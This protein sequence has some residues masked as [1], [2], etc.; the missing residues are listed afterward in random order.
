M[1]VEVAIV[2][3][4]VAGYACAARL[5]RHG[6]PPLLI[7]P[8]LPVDR[9]PLTKTALAKGEP[10]A[11]RRRTAPRAGHR[12]ARRRRRPGRPRAAPGAVV[13]GRSRSRR[14]RSCSRRAS[15]SAPPIP[16]RAAHVNAT[17]AGCCAVAEPLAGGRGRV[18]VVGGGLV[19]RRRRY[20]RRR[21]SRRDRLDVLDRPAD[22]LHDAAAGA[23]RRLSR[24]GRGGVPRRGAARAG[25]G[26]CRRRARRPSAPCWR[27]TS[28]SR[29][30][31][32]AW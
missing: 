17:P 29:R 14:T 22:R 15:R 25:R 8:G 2:G 11:R 28:S 32:G 7:G 5:A 23:P 19:G 21:R 6:H 12:P 27:P 9:P 13:A 16:A 26:A 10:P 24:R 3:N 18:V 20:P 4:G 30:P 31:V 1:T